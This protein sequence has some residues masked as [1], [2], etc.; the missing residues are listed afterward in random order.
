MF[1]IKYEGEKKIV[2]SNIGEFLTLRVLA[3]LFVCLFVFYK[4]S[5]RGVRKINY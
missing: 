1:Y 4:Q 5:W 2:P 3:L